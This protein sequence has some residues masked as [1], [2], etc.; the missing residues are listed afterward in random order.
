MPD[1]TVPDGTSLNGTTL[2]HPMAG[3]PWYDASQDAGDSGGDRAPGDGPTARYGS[4]PWWEVGAEPE[5]E[6]APVTAWVAPAPARRSRL[7]RATLA[8]LLLT[9]GALWL[10]ASLDL[11][12]ISITDGLALGLLGVGVALV[13]AAWVGHAYALIPVGV[14]LTAALVVGELIDIPLDAGV[15][16]RTVVVTTAEEMAATHQ[17]V[18]GDL[19]LDLSDAPLAPDGGTPTVEAEL[20]AG[21]LEVIVPRDATVELH[22]ASR[23]GDLQTPDDSATVKDE[24]GLDET[25]TLEGEPGGGQVELDLSVDVGDVI[26]TRSPAGSDGRSPIDDPTT[27]TSTGGA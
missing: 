8:L 7:G 19:T 12:T 9:G 20:G 3:S 25:L 23:A 27:P 10:A 15:G 11:F 21:D 6:P 4:R 16:D 17:L 14:L 5:V 2:R 13:V 1:D 22:A 26:I 24:I 18:A